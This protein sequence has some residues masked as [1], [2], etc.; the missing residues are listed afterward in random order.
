MHRTC[1]PVR[2]AAPQPQPRRRRRARWSLQRRTVGAVCA[3]G[4]V[5]VGCAEAPS[6]DPHAAPEQ[7]T[8]TIVATHPFDR[9]SFTQGLEL[10]EDTLWVS[11][12]WWGESE[13]YRTSIDGHDRT[14]GVKLPAE[15]FGEG[16]TVV[17]DHLWQLTWKAGTAYRRATDTLEVVDTATYPGQGWGLCHTDR[18]LVMSDGTAE[19]R[20][21][22][23][24]SFE[25]RSRVTV[26]AQGTP[27]D[28]LNELDC[29]EEHG[30][31]VV[32]A[33][34]W[35]STDIVRIDLDTG[36]V[37]AVVDASG[38]PNRAAVD[39]NN[40]LNGIAHIAGSDRFLLTG[41]RWPDLYE[42][43]FTPRHD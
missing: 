38:L 32:Y 25:E 26:R 9:T 18:A 5:L 41:K 15:Q 23:P 2:P 4:L 42:V 33:N 27:V 35:K 43:E 17:G 3:A 6:V 20:L 1:A 14:P 37:T 39:S 12:G 31:W 16:M 28:Q 19:L 22:D 40:V 10:D 11:T 13:V 29:R 34:V 36:V 7:L 30:R 21:L 8:A 24:E